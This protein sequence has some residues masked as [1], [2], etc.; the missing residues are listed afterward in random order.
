[1]LTIV[2]G[3]GL[4]RAQGCW[5][6]GQYFAFCS[7]GGCDNVLTLPSCMIG[8]ISGDCHPDGNSTSCC[9]L[10]KAYAQIFPDGGDCSGGNCGLARVR[11]AEMRAKKAGIVADVKSPNPLLRLPPRR[12]FVP[13]TCT[14]EYEIVY[15]WEFPGFENEGR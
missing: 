1:L 2:L 11:R 8:C 3:S 4:A 14:H 7:S 5:S 12:L 9:G 15:E 13:N 6:Y 10:P